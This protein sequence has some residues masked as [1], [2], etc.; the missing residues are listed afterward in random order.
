MKRVFILLV[1]LI[2]LVGIDN[3]SAQSRNSYFM[4]GS[5]FRNDLNPALTPTRGYVALPAISGFG[6]N[7][8]N[9][10][11]SVD[12]FIYQRDGQLVTALHGSVS[13]EEFFGK[14]PSEG[15]LAI[16]T[17]VN[18]FGVGFY[19]KKMF[20]TFG[21]DTITQCFYSLEHIHGHS[22]IG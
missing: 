6:L 5:Y 13:S 11:L 2:T 7:V 4:E 16:D 8:S 20:W 1:G 9:N 10:F 3:V 18:L 21:V 17:K 19:V 14:L 12:N 15:K 22:H